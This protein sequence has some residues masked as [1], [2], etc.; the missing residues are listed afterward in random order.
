MEPHLP[1]IVMA[2]KAERQ[3][4]SR[5]LEVG[6]ARPEEEEAQALQISQLRSSFLHTE[7]DQRWPLVAYVVADLW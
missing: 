7:K 3:G 6:Q 5:R 1:S 4:E 2:A